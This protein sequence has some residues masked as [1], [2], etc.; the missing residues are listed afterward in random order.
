MTEE[1]TSVEVAKVEE[2]LVE[3]KKSVDEAAVIEDNSTTEAIAKSADAIVKDNKVLVEGVSS[4]IDS[5]VAKLD[6]MIENI[7]KLEKSVTAIEAKVE[8]FAT[9]PSAPKAVI[10]EAETAPAEARAPMQKSLTHA[11]V[12]AKATSAL[13]TA[14]QD[15]AMQ[16]KMGIAQLDAGYSPEQ[17]AKSLNLL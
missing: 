5:L 7:G 11:D 16:I 4:R 12:V 8:T 2:L 15:R 14:N 10:V 3:L 1:Q 13:A 6:S 9:T 17:I